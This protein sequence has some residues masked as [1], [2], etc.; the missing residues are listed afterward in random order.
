MLNLPLFC[1]HIIEQIDP[2][3]EL[4]DHLKLSGHTLSVYDKSFDLSR[5]KSIQILGLGKAA[6]KQVQ[7]VYDL[8]SNEK[9]LKTPLVVTKYEHSESSSKFEVIESSHPLS[10]ENSLKA[11]ARVKELVSSLSKEDLLIVCLSGGASS[12]ALLPPGDLTLNDINSTCK[13]LLWGNAPVEEINALRR[14]ICELKNG[15]TLALCSADTVISLLI[16]DIP[17]GDITDIG[18]GPTFFKALNSEDLPLLRDTPSSK[19]LTEFVNSPEN[20][21]LNQIKKQKSEAI[22][23]SF[24]SVTDLSHALSIAQ[25]ELKALEYSTFLLPEDLDEQDFNKGVQNQLQYFKTLIE[26]QK[27]PTALVSAGEYRL[28]IPEEGS[29]GGRNQ[30]FT[31]TLIHELFQLNSLQLSEDQL[32][33]IQFL[34][35]GTDGTDGPTKSAGAYFEW[36]MFKLV[37]PQTIQKHLAEF[38]SFEFFKSYGGHIFTGPTQ[39]NLND[40]RVI[41]YNPN[42]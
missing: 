4:K 39:N 41:M 31:L 1:N 20:K 33:C 6:F 16:N 35:L 18:S 26:S 15:G 24:F 22:D 32:K 3:L 9:H 10:D 11:G 34:S 23:H 25:R 36:E 13:E 5:F 12:L 19:K 40:L 28:V 27:K 7:W 21:E 38:T 29:L 2:C 37:N 8:L 42:A 14:Q 17:T 30:H